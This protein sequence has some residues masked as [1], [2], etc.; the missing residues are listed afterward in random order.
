M[1]V[2]QHEHDGGGGRQPSEQRDHCVVEAAAVLEIDPVGEEVGEERCQVGSELLGERRERGGTDRVD[3][4]AVG[5]TPLGLVR[6][7]CDHR[8]AARLSGGAD[9]VQQPGLAD[10]RL[11]QEQQQFAPSGVAAAAPRE[12][13]REHGPLC[14]APHEG[15]L[16]FT[17]TAL[18]GAVSG[19][20]RQC[21]R[22]AG[23]RRG[24]AGHEGDPPVGRPPV[25]LR[26]LLEDG[27]LE[28]A[29]LCRRLDPEFLGQEPARLLVSAKG[30]RLAARPVQGEHEQPPQALPQ[31]VLS[32]AGFQGGGHLPVAAGG[33]RAFGFELDCASPQLAQPD[34]LGL[35]ERL[36]AHVGERRPPPQRQCAAHELGRARD[37][38]SREGGPRAREP[39]L[40]ADAVDGLRDDLDGV[41]RPTGGDQLRPECLAELGDVVLEYSKPRGR[42]AVRPEVVEEALAGHDLVVVD[43]QVDEERALLGA[44][45][46]DGYSIPQHFQW[47]QDPELHNSRA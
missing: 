43:E 29:Q 45:R 47:P 1:D 24:V 35:S 11:A 46:L 17:F 21:R 33:E 30:V 37:V 8:G 7:A 2:V 26:S 15:R 20:W 6:T 10:A 40:E 39:L 27:D 41:A 18:R 44:E 42:R 28:L 14:G 3:P 5:T 9:V 16:S 19:E 36:A 13:L 32:Q 4:G 23:E 31:R 25:E 38:A 34:D 22:R 12:E